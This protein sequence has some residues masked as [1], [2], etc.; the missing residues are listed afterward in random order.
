ML[1]YIS[2]IIIGM[3]LFCQIGIGEISPL[4]KNYTKTN[5]LNN[6]YDMIIITPNKFSKSIQ[7]LIEHKNNNKIITMIKTTE[8]IYSEYEG[9]DAAEK[10]K[11]FIKDAI[12]SHNSRYILLMGGKKILSFNWNVPARYSN[13]ADGLGHE[14]FLS[15]LYFADIYKEN[16]DFEDWDSNGNGIYAEWGINGDE[17]DLN[18]DIAIGRLPCRT[19][20][21]V[22]T[23]VNKIITYENNAYSKSW[24]KRLVV[25]GGD[26]FPD[27]EDY[28]GELTCDAAVDY[29]TDFDIIKLYTSNGELK[30]PEDIVYELNNG[31]GFF[32]T[33]GKGGTDRI[34]MVQPEGP[35]FIAFNIDH[36]SD[37][38]NKDMYPICILGEC[39][40]GRFDVGIINI[41]KLI[42][43]DPEYNIYDCI[44]E[45]IAWR[46]IREKDAGAIASIT[47]TNICFGAFGDND[48][49][50]INDDAEMYG[51]FLIVELFRIYSEEKID[52]LGDLHK[53]AISSYIE[54]F[55]VYTNK[56]HSK[57]IQEFIL[58]GDPSLKIGGY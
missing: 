18:P 10:V 17:L 22:E 27:Y 19:R 57:S 26:T 21:E 11:Y 7:P 2:I 53:N 8:E 24:F 45:C 39:I 56:I 25:V 44:P 33:R 14:I 13:L 49:N 41:I 28:E 42:Q 31:C 30:S 37:L 47:N 40:H 36:I 43:G 20:N 55:P 16:G 29:M 23:V 9:R 12:E 46:L 32:M 38:N 58:F 35:E 6:E 4:N 15:D 5:S 48:D 54:I 52:I 3:L 34:R 51:G 1:R 50:G